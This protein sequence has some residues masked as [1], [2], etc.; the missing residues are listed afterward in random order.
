MIYND[1]TTDLTG[2]R[3]HRLFQ[4]YEQPEYVKTAALQER[5]SDAVIPLASYADP[6]N[7]LYPCDSPASTWISAAYFYNDGNND[8]DVEAR[9]LKAAGH[10]GRLADVQRLK[11]Q[12]QAKAAGVQ[13]EL[14]DEDFALVRKF[15]DGTTDRKYRLS[16]AG[17]VKVA[18][19]YLC[20]HRA[21]FQFADRQTIAEKIL[22]KAEYFGVGLG[23]NH[24]VLDRI[25]GNGLAPSD[26]VADMLRTRA[27]VA[28]TKNAELGTALSQ[29]ADAV[30]TNSEQFSQFTKRAELAAAVDVVDREL[31][32]VARYGQGVLDFPEDTIFAVTEKQAAEVMV[33]RVTLPTGNSY[34]PN[35]FDQVPVSLFRDTLGD[36][37]AN[38]VSDP[39]GN[40]DQAKVAG[41]VQDLPLA[42]VRRFEAELHNTN[43]T[44]D[45]QRAGKTGYSLFNTPAVKTATEKHAQNAKPGSLWDRQTKIQSQF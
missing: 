27:R 28:M 29:M 15:E 43:V 39:L 6:A 4:L 24:D 35:A 22:K 36:H 17:E 25:A 9:L 45:L 2:Q 23:A 31:G 14:P 32:L 13:L 10:F 12:V 42:D 18:A 41:A 40:V 7:K 1:Q 11:Q 20:K 38:A 8:R 19:E 3:T 21:D 34:P 37:V 30:A 44:L 5:C 26:E 16:N 33:G